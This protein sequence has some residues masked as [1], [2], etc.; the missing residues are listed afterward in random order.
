MM[1]L[2][3]RIRAQGTTCRALDSSIRQLAER[4]GSLLTGTDSPIPGQTY[5]ASVHGEMAL[6]VEAGLTPTQ[7]LEA[8][9]SAPATAFQLS[10]RGAIRPHPILS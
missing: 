3:S 9:T 2:P 1:T 5:D 7:A 6:L 4:G 10:D 8:A